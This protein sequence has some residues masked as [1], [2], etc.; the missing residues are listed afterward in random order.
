[1]DS[2]P[3]SFVKTVETGRVEGLEVY[4]PD[5]LYA[6]MVED[7]GQPVDALG[8]FELA[9]A[10]EGAGLY[11]R[12]QEH[13]LAV[14]EFDPGFKSDLIHLRLA[15]VAIKIEDAEETAALDDIRNRLYRKDFALAL[16]MVEQFRDEYPESRQR[17]ELDG[18]EGEIRTA[19]RGHYGK[20][21][22]SDYFSRLDRRLSFVARDA[23]M[24]LDVAQEIAQTETHDAIVEELASD[25]QLTEETIQELWDA[26][27]GGSPRSARVKPTVA[28]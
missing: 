1:M 3:R 25:Y 24:T 20:T 2:F 8:H 26:R 17:S 16:E 4:R 13:Y 28:I 19:K 22:V 9:R 27:R 15:R 10:T 12:A 5:D 21:I 18:L 7:L 11:A 14:Q 23:G 6:V